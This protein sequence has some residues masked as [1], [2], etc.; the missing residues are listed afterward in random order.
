VLS[1]SFPNIGPLTL[2]PCLLLLCGFVWQVVLHDID[3]LAKIFIIQLGITTVLIAFCYAALSRRVAPIIAATSMAMPIQLSSVA[4]F[5]AK[6]HLSKLFSP[7]TICY[8]SI[9]LVGLCCVLLL[10]VSCL[11]SESTQTNNNT[12]DSSNSSH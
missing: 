10:I 4:R 11:K 12:S 1:Q 8:I 3:L 9:A 6:E 7:L 5:L 2:L